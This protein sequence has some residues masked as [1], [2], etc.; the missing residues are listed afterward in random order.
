MEW[1]VIARRQAGAVSRAQCRATGLTDR[2]VD[3]LLAA[4]HLRATARRS[5]FVAA[6]AGF[7]PE[8]SL[9][10]AVL[11]TAGVV[12]HVSAAGWWGI[13]I[14]NRPMGVHVTV[15]PTLRGYRLPGVTIH[16][17]AV[18]AS[19]IT[20]RL[21]LPTTSVVRT[22][23]DCLGSLP[24]PDARTMADR[25]LQRRLLTP[26]DLRNR[27]LN[28]PNRP[29][30]GQIGTL[31]RETTAAAAESER[32]LHRLLHAAG[33]TGWIANLAVW[34]EGARYEIDVAFVEARLAIEIDGWAFHSDVDRFQADRR[35][36]NSLTLAGWTVVRFTWADLM[37][38]PAEVVATIRRSL[39]LTSG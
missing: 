38:R 13:E 25:C 34:V 1:T 28:E 33:V 3:L 31:L 19:D 22:V 5:V 18:P 24:P 11:A 17:A 26:A 9:W 23:L 36:Q 2:Q 4:G 37:Q 12:S 8:Q 6:A 16:R 7:T 27:L 10:T 20:H 39:E 21:R 30:N 32:R 15:D 29:G 14:P 35:R